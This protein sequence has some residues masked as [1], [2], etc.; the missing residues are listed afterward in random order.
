MY[1][2]PNWFIPLYFSPFSLSPFLVVISTDLKIEFL[3]YICTLVMAS[4]D[5]FWID[6]DNTSHYTE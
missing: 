2:N 3:F 1:Y 4:V 5:I 6:T